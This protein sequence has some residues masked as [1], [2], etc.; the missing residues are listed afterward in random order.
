MAAVASVH[1][2]DHRHRQPGRAGNW[3]TARAVSHRPDGARSPVGQPV[4]FSFGNRAGSAFTA[5]AACQ[6]HRSGS[7]SGQSG[8]DPRCAGAHDAGT[9]DGHP[10]PDRH[11]ARRVWSFAPGVCTGCRG[12][13]Q[14]RHGDRRDPSGCCPTCG[15]FCHYCRG[16][17]GLPIA[18]AAVPHLSAVGHR[19]R[20]GQRRLQS[21]AGTKCP[22]HGGTGH[23]T[24]GAHR[25]G[26]TNA[27]NGAGSQRAAGRKKH[28]RCGD[29]GF[30]QGH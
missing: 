17:H 3:Q 11:H 24:G 4:D 23:R 5:H 21:T 13:G 14:H 29:A 26:G 18:G 30:S 15:A 20:P 27:G 2:P 6:R 10:P 16:C 28:P 22:H 1:P 8:A 25:S 12:F 9:P 7:R 19:H